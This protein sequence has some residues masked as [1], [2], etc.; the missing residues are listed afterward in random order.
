MLA[1]IYCLLAGL[2]RRLVCCLQLADNFYPPPQSSN[3]HPLPTAPLTNQVSADTADGWDDEWDD[4]ETISSYSGGDQPETGTLASLPGR[5]TNSLG[6]VR[7]GT[8]R[9]SM[10]R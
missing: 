9:K 8:V 2:V 3:S 10:N 4:D 1:F 5:E 6:I 7:S